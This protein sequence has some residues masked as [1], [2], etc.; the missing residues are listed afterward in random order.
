VP[1]KDGRYCLDPP[2][3]VERS[4]RSFGPNLRPRPTPASAEAKH[5][6]YKF[7]PDGAP[8]EQIP[9]TGSKGAEVSNP[10]VYYATAFKRYLTWIWRLC[11]DF[12]EEEIL[13]LADDIAAVFRHVLYHPNIAMA[14]GVVLEQYLII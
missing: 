13:L 12:A 2:T 4:T 5:S 14:F 3:Q 6:K 7:S 8:N 1:E 11:I 9:D 10:K